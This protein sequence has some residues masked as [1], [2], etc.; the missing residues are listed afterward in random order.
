MNGSTCVDGINGYNC[1]CAAGYTGDR[2]E[3]GR[4]EHVSNAGHHYM[5]HINSYEGMRGGL[6]I[7]IQSDKKGL[8]FRTEISGFHISNRNKIV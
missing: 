2:C 4:F 5:R 1:T 8:Q 6:W 7:T 3:T